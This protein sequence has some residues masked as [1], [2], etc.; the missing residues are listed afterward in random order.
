MTYEGCSESK[1]QT[2]AVCGNQVSG[3]MAPKHPERVGKLVVTARR[4]CHG[5][6]RASTSVS[7][8][9]VTAGCL[10]RLQ[11]FEPVKQFQ[12]PQNTDPN[13]LRACHCVGG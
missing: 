10:P 6:A 4:M 13:S 2:G 1:V 9:A 12:W 3:F 8:P 11:M 5:C 7:I